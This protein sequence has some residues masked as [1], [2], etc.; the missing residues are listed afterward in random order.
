MEQIDAD[1]MVSSSR[2]SSEDSPPMSDIDLDAHLIHDSDVESDP[3]MDTFPVEA[4]GS[5]LE[6]SRAYQYDCSWY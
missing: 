1:D 6:T 4:T 5:D 2:C 3:V